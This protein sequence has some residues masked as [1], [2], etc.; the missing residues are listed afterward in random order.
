MCFKQLS[1]K[2]LNEWR[3]TIY[4]SS[5]LC[6]KKWK[7]VNTTSVSSSLGYRNWI[8]VDMFMIQEAYVPTM[9]T[10]TCGYFC[11][12]NEGWQAWMFTYH[13][14]NPV[15]TTLIKVCRFCF[16]ELILPFYHLIFLFWMFF[17]LFWMVYF[18]LFVNK[19]HIRYRNDW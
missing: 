15:L 12:C 3:H 14:Q 9:I 5:S 11:R 2:E 8:S 19:F 1:F 6:Y 17:F 7:S 16:A 18:D 4:S 10:T 13:L